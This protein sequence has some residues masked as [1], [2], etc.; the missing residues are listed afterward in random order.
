MAEPTKFEVKDFTGA[1]FVNKRDSPNPNAPTHT[2]NAR[3][4]G[5]LMRV[6]AWSKDTQ[7]GGS[8]L[9]LRFTPEDEQ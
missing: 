7:N 1:L 4:N 6:S 2:G 8:M 9:S 5:I 3:I